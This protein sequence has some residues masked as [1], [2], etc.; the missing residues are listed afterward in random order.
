MVYSHT[1][2]Q[3][4]LSSLQ[5]M[6]RNIEEKFAAIAEKHHC[7]LVISDA[8]HTFVDRPKNNPSDVIRINLSDGI[9][10]VESNLSITR[11]DKVLKRMAVPHERENAKF[12]GG[13]VTMKLYYA[14]KHL[15]AAMDN[16]YGPEDSFRPSGRPVGPRRR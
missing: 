2:Y 1:K 16:E 4:T 7:S 10:R 6:R 5:E 14:E 12:A 8:S 11:L 9:V 13:A 3:E 15:A